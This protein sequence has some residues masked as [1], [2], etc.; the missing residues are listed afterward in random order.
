MTFCKA[1]S[2]LES[3]QVHVIGRH[4]EFVC[5]GMERVLV[6][7]MWNDTIVSLGVTRFESGIKDFIIC[8]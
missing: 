2:L 3:K 4:D 7:F 6:A 1:A 8:L 5:A